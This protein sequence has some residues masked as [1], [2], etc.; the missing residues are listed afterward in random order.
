MDK[1]LKLL[2]IGYFMGGIGFGLVIATML[3]M[4]V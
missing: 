4:S 3:F 1:D 2:L